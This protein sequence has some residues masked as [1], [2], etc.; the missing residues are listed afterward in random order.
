MYSILI[1][2]QAEKKEEGGKTMKEVLTVFQKMR[3]RSEEIILKVG[4][5]AVAER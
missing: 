2:S 3:T 5:R 4:G 1:F